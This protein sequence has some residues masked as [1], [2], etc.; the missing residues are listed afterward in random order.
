MNMK[1]SIKRAVW[2][3]T[4]AALAS[5]LLFS[6]VTTANILRIQSVQNANTQAAELL[7][8]AQSAETAH[9]RWA[10]GLSN[11]L[12]AGAEFTGSTDPTTCTLGQWIYGNAEISDPAILA[13]RNELE[14]LHK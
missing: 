6:F 2:I 3:R 12:Y 9:Y 4:V 5:I 7:Q 11:A 1:K 13:L 10:S 8:R 14:P